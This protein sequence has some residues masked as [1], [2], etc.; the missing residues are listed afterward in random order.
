MAQTRDIDSHEQTTGWVGW[1]YFAGFMMMLAG[2]FHAIAPRISIARE[3]RH[4]MALAPRAATAVENG[5]FI[6]S[7]S[8]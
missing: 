6:R 7:R 5:I 1:V 8:N 3:T 2:I 4:R